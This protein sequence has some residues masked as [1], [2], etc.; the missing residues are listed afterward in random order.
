MVRF[1]VTTKPPTNKRLM[2]VFNLV[3]ASVYPV[4]PENKGGS[5]KCVSRKERRGNQGPGIIKNSCRH[6]VCSCKHNVC[7]CRHDACNQ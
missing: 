4:R 2:C 1:N 6:D 7:S 5:V 3:K